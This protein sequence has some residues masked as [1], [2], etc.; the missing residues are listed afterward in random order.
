MQVHH[1][2]KQQ[3][4]RTL[5][6]TYQCRRSLA[7]CF[8]RRRFT[9]YLPDIPVMGPIVSANFHFYSMETPYKI[10]A[11]IGLAV[12]ENKISENI[13]ERTMNARQRTTDA[14][15]SC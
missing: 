10:L 3:Y 14:C 15:L 13:K 6:P 9:N 1:L 8:S 4:A 12:L 11:L 7:F 5:S 2:N